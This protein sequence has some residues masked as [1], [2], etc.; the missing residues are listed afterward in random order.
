[1]LSFNLN[2]HKLWLITAVEIVS[3][4]LSYQPQ[5]FAKYEPNWMHDLLEHNYSI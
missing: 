3:S 4:S 5:L 2:G 1:M